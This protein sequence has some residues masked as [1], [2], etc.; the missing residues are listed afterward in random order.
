MRV[1]AVLLLAVLGLAV[2]RPQWH[3]LHEYSF[4]QYEQEYGKVYGTEQERLIRKKIFEEKLEE[5][6]AHNSDPSKSWKKGVNHFTDLTDA[7]FKRMLGNK[8]NRARNPSLEFSQVSQEQLK[9]YEAADVDWRTKGAVTDVK[10]QG[11]CGS[12]WTFATAETLES[13]WF[14]AGHKLP[15]LSEQQIIDCTPNPNHCGGTGG[16]E[17]GTVELA[18][19]RIIAMGGLASESDYPY[20]GVDGTCQFSGNTTNPAATLSGWKDL[21]S[22]DYASV[23]AAIQKGPLAI[24]VDASAWSSYDSGVFSC[25]MSAPDIDHAV[26]LVGY[27]TDSASGSLFW[28]VRNSWSSGW[29]EDGYIRLQRFSSNNPCGEDTTPADGDGCSGGPAEVKV[30]GSCGILYDVCYPI[31]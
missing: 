26:Q 23:M 13:W 19:D 2:A 11:S 6:K 10:D 24:S 5:F 22:N 29:G 20:Q 31:I 8:H 7:E 3:Q 27:G 14:L 21:L 30:C 18:Y 16:C 4:E 28:L 9:Q 25:D 12:C 1:L 15:V 17:G